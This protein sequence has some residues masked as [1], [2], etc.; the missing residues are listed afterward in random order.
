MWRELSWEQRRIVPALDLALVKG[1]F[2]DTPGKRGAPIE[3]MWLNDIDFDGRNVTG[4]LLQPPIRLKSVAE[5]DRVRVS[6]GRL[7]DW[8]YAIAGEVYGAFSIDLLRSE[9]SVKERVE[10]DEGW[11]LDFGEPGT[12]K[13]VPDNQD[14]EEEHPMCLNMAKSFRSFL[15]KD[16]DLINNADKK[17][18]TLLHHQ[19][20]AGNK[21]IVDILLKEGANPKAKTKKGRTALDLAKAAPWPKIE[22]TL[23][24]LT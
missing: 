6:L 15:S 1:A 12:I 8:M 13:I 23:R 19:A 9:L 24:P 10:H 14:P 16:P 2:C 17:G 11:D 21:T 22:A 7:G 18:W 20:L 3:H 5:G 4:V